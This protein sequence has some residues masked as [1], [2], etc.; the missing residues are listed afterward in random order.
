MDQRWPNPEVQSAHFTG[1]QE[2]CTGQTDVGAL[3]GE[4]DAAYREE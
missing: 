1:V 2:L 3:L 4:M